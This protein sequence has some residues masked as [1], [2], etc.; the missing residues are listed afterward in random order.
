MIRL[1]G[2]QQAYATVE[3]Q[4]AGGNSLSGTSLWAF[5]ISPWFSG[6]AT[7]SSGGSVSV[8]YTSSASG[9][10]QLR[11][12]LTTTV[13]WVITGYGNT[14]VAGTS[15]FQQTQIHTMNASGGVVVLSNELFAPYWIP[16]IW[17]SY[18][19]SSGGSA[20]VSSSGGLT[21]LCAPHVTG[22]I[23]VQGTWSPT[24]LLGGLSGSTLTGASTLSLFVT[25]SGNVQL[26]SQTVPAVQVISQ[27]GM[28][29]T[30]L[31][32]HL[33]TYTPV[34]SGSILLLGSGI[35]TQPVT[36]VTGDGVIRVRGAAKHD[37]LKAHNH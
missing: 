27:A 19:C 16:R 30:G 28:T 15:T 1:A 17:V 10:S 12:G 36:L 9:A 29:V 32:T 3:T 18:L 5:V 8:I 35:I 22:S 25:T 6:S 33:L 14:V 7:L 20:L 34:G 26:L 11:S 37:L 21:I 4:M 24:I 13:E 2:T 31:T 23:H